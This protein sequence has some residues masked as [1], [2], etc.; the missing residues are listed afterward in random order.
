MWLLELEG[1]VVG[2]MLLKGFLKCSLTAK[3]GT[4]K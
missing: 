4:Q 1:K 3:S 2:K